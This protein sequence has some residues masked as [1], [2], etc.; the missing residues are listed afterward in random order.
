M[1]QKNSTGLNWLDKLL[2]FCINKKGFIEF[3]D[4]VDPL[5][6]IYAMENKTIENDFLIVSEIEKC[7]E[8]GSKLYRDGKDKFEINNTTS[9]Y[10]QKYQCSNNE[11]NHNLRPLW[12]D[13]FKPGSNY[14]ERIKG[15]ILELGLICNISYQQAAEI[16]YMFTGCE[17]RRDT[18]YKFCDAEINEFL[19][20]KEKEIQQAVKEANIEFSDSLSYDEQ[21]VFTTDAGWVYRLAAIDPVSNYPYANIILK[22]DEF[23]SENIKKFLQPI[24]DE[25]EIKTIVTDGAISY[26][27]IVAELGCNHK[28]CNFHKMQNFM[29]KIKGTLR[30]LNNKIKSNKDKIKTNEN[31]I[32]E[33]K[34]LRTGEVGRVNLNDKD[35]RNLVDE[36]KSLER[37]NRK[38]RQENRNYK[39]E[40]KVYDKCTHNLS[41]MLKSRT[42]KTGFKCYNKIIDEIDDTPEK[43]RGFIRNIQKELD[44]LLLHTACDDIPTTNN[45]IELYFG[46]T[47]NRRLKR[48]YKTQRGILNEIRLKTIRWIKR[49]VLS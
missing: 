22:K 15:L 19:I 43:I 46:V 18:T 3:C 20:K 14:T 41:L 10:K 17:I 49:V 33:I 35:A 30:G 4:D 2:S 31:R 45:C 9:V 48:K 21:Y 24:V 34:N 29:N 16:L 36:K 37:E 47:L 13:Y 26:P 32:I 27:S 12:E 39:T 7:P 5:F 28:K 8:C 25:H 1:L 23:N 40:I 44:N 38:L 42:K 11:C 6:I